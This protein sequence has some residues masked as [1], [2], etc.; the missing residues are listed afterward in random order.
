M[1]THFEGTMSERIAEFV[2]ELL[3]PDGASIRL[4]RSL[5]DDL[6][7]ADELAP[8]LLD[9][10]RH[11]STR[12][13]VD[14]TSLALR[15]ATGPRYRPV[16]EIVLAEGRVPRRMRSSST[17]RGKSSTGTRCCGGLTCSRADATVSR[18]CAPLSS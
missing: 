18:G 12:G 17:R 2:T 14:A 16:V 4:Y 3:S 1:L 7:P 10:I 15:L 11:A 8:V 5:R 6:P 9:S 13:V